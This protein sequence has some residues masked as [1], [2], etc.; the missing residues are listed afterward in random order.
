MSSKKKAGVK[1]G[2]PLQ[3]LA[4]QIKK[5]I[6]RKQIEAGIIGLGYVGL[7]L[8]VAFARAG[9]RVT[10]F[11]VDRGKV[12][13]IREGQSYIGDVPSEQVRDMVRRKRL[14]ATTDFNELRRMDTINI[15]V[16]TPLRKS[17][18]PDISYV[19]S[20]V[21]EVEARSRPGQIVILESTTY[22]GTTTEILQPALERRGRK[23]GVDAFVAFS[24]ER[25]DPANKKYTIENTPK[26][27]GGV[28]PVCTDLATSF[29]RLAIEDVIPV[30]SPTVA[31]MVKLLEN[32]YRAINIGLAN[33]IAQLCHRLKIDV[34]EVIDAAGTKPFGFAAFYPGP[35][36][37]GHCIPIDPLYLAWRV[38]LFNVTAKFI[39]LATEVNSGMPGFVIE[40]IVELLNRRKKA[41]S[42]SRILI[43]GVTYKR[44]VADVRESPSVEIIEKLLE[45]GAEVTV[46]DPFL[47][48]LWAGHREIFTQ[49]VTPDL[50]RRQDVALV[51]TDHTSFDYGL[52]ASQAPLVFDTRNA[53]RRALGRIPQNVVRL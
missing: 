24:P 20:A 7:P 19:V 53:I 32:T 25:V 9:V 28:T 52:I 40:R 16:P 35:G 48:S 2:K 14:T 12:S 8:A 6:Y 33:E 47:T 38:K 36:L 42:G 49:P 3:P 51:L 13:Q 30:S 17:K 39:E 34:W 44:D 18:D 23:I 46:S 43:L 5:K 27:V 11:D 22:P 4:E 29:Y 26:V 15:C 10:G 31:E 37:G 45:L 1:G 50:L 41:V 21:R